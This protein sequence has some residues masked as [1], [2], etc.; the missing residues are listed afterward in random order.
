MMRVGLTLLAA[1]GL[2]CTGDAAVVE[3]FAFQLRVQTDM[4]DVVPNAVLSRDGTT[5]GHTDARGTREVNM[6]GKE[7]QRVLFEVACPQGFRQRRASQQVV[8]RPVAAL[9]RGS[10]A[11]R[12]EVTLTCVPVT[13]FGVL[14]VRV[15]GAHGV[16]VLVDERMV[17]TTNAAGIAHVPLSLVPE[18]SL[19]VSLDTSAVPRL[20][21]ANPS[22]RFVIEDRDA[23]LVFD[24]T[25]TEVKQPQRR[26]HGRTRDLPYRL[27]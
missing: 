27:N 10:D 12:R 16:P 11:R 18:S 5:L 22:Q 9:T 19:R 23:L 2:A 25:L 24:Q 15:A 14:V 8:L 3:I 7:G 1:I 20:R 4:G 21:P 13:R 17:A 6:T 26:K